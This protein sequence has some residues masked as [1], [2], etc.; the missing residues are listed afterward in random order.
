MPTRATVTR[1][2]GKRRFPRTRT[3]GMSMAVEATMSATAPLVRTT[4]LTTR[5]HGGKRWRAWQSTSHCWLALLK[6]KCFGQITAELGT[7][8]KGSSKAQHSSDSKECSVDVVFV[9]GARAGSRAT[10]A[11]QTNVCGDTYAGGQAARTFAHSGAQARQG[12]VA[13]VAEGGGWHGGK[14]A[15]HKNRARRFQ[16]ASGSTATVAGKAAVRAATVALYAGGDVSRRAA[17]WG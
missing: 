1:W 17:A 8:T 2:V 16:Q 15:A 13:A 5:I 4:V 6:A 3:Y 11:E 9:D 12:T 10:R 14:I 7:S